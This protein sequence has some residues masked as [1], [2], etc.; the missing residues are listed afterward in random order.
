MDI[1]LC[2]LTT[3]WAFPQSPELLHLDRDSDAPTERVPAYPVPTPERWA[4]S[5]IAFWESRLVI[6]GADREH[7]IKGLLGTY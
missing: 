2:K 1:T 5:K 4:D 3:V 6:D 7:K